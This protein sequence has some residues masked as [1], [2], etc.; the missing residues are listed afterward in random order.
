MFVDILMFYFLLNTQK[1]IL[2]CGKSVTI[3]FNCFTCNGGQ[4]LPVSNML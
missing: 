4:W 1:K 2:E 3:D